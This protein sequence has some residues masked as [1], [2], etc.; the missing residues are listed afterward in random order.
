M[1]NYFAK[2][3][4]IFLCIGF[5][6]FLFNQRI[7][8]QEKHNFLNFNDIL[9]RLT[10]TSRVSTS[11]EKINEQ[12][13]K[14][15]QKRK[16]NF[17]LSS[18]D[19]N[20]LKKAGASDSLIKAIREN[21]PNELKENLT[22]ITEQQALYKEF[23][24]NYNGSIEQ[25]KIALV[26]AKE[27]V[28]K[29]SD[30]VEKDI[31]DYLVAVIPQ[32]EAMVN[33]PG[34]PIPDINKTYRKFDNSLKNEKLDELFESGAEILKHQPE[35]VDVSLVLAKAGFENTVKELNRKYLQQ[36]LDYAEKSIELLDKNAFSRTGDYGVKQY[37]YKTK[38]FPDGK[39]NALGNMNYIIG[40]LK[41]FYLSQKDEA[42]PYFQKSLQF[43]SDSKDALR[44]LNLP[45]EI[46]P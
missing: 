35:F 38:I 37:S 23:T 46:K 20:S 43:K 11:T 27:F 36:T 22:L 15:V 21:L 25:K 19:Q 29:Y 4:G 3:A 7:Q 28:K 40:Y 1:K 16:V 18:K 2:A 8:G 12:L 5:F 32:L 9:T 44:K 26:A 24:G 42:A 45:F 30:V 33:F 6:V 10:F 14:N 41:Y 34:D 31:I 39:A 13:I 17:I